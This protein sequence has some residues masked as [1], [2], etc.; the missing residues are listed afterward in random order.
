MTLTF[1]TYTNFATELAQFL[2][3]YSSEEVVLCPIEKPKDLKP[4]SERKCRFCARSVPQTT[5]NNEPHV[6]P[7]LLGNRY[8]VSDFECDSCNTAF[9]K[10]EN[11]LAYFLGITRTFQGVK[12]K[13]N[14][15]PV[16][17]SSGGL[18]SVRT[19]DFHGIENGLKI[20]L[21]E[22]NQRNFK[23]NLETGKTTLKYIKNKYIPLNVYKSFL[24]IALSVLPI[25]YLDN[26]WRTFQLLAVDSDQFRDVAKVMI[27]ELPNHHNVGIP[28]CYLFTKKNK[29]KKLITHIFAFYFQNLIFQFII[30]LFDKDIE[31]GLY[32]GNTFTVPTCPPL[33]LFKPEPDLNY[34]GEIRDFSSTE[35]INEEGMISFETNPETLKNFQAYDPKTG[36]SSPTSLNSEDIV[37]IYLAPAGSKMSFQKS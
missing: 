35:S 23:F 13:D 37:A 24:K 5:F 8:W 14:K 29:S 26:Y 9:G 2:Q 28:V 11:D 34:S 33:L 30:P 22:I 10:Y 7:H 25:R 21:G 17:K 19:Q 1:Y 36:K 31:I 4:K 27:H 20:D 16:F 15:V 6:I 18:L 12:N 3:K 32:N